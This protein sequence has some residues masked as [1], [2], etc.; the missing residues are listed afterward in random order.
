M[1]PYSEKSNQALR[2]TLTRHYLPQWT[3]NC[4]WADRFHQR[5]NSLHTALVV[6]LPSLRQRTILPPGVTFVRMW[7]MDKMRPKAKSDG[8]R[9]TTGNFCPIKEGL[10]WALLE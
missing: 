9:I 5:A 3:L 6:I 1:Q 4:P 7:Q 10:S 2:P 8:Y